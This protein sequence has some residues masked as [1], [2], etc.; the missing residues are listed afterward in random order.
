M[1]FQPSGVRTKGTKTRVGLTEVSQDRN[2]K[3]YSWN[4]MMLQRWVDLMKDL[5]TE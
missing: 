4:N 3:G 1:Y 5:N 2:P